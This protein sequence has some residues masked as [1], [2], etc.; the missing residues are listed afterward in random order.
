MFRVCIILT[1]CTRRQRRYHCGNDMRDLTFT[2]DH[3]DLPHLYCNA[4]FQLIY[5]YLLLFHKLSKELIFSPSNSSYP[6]M[7]SLSR[8][9]LPQSH[10]RHW[11]WPFPQFLEK[12]QHLLCFRVSTPDLFPFPATHTCV[13]AHTYMCI[14][15]FC[16]SLIPATSF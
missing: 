16:C 3:R 12:H 11:S 15:N 2:C 9:H 4:D 6:N 7:V 13:H 14:H 5:F 10:A 8:S 1:H